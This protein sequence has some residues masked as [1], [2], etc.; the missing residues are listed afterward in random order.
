MRAL[1]ALA[2]ALTL[3]ACGGTVTDAADASSDGS[4]PDV[5]DDVGADAAGCVSACLGARLDWEWNGGLALY[6][7]KSAALPC[8]TYQRQRFGTPNDT[9]PTLACSSTIRHCGGDVV[10]GSNA[11]AIEEIASAVADAEVQTAFAHAPVLYGIDPRAYDGQVFRITMGTKMIEVG[12]AC[13]STAGC[14]AAPAGV[15]ALATLLQEL[16]T[17]KTGADAC[18]QFR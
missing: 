3:A 1:P 11:I 4:V 13:G 6:Y 8:N 17:R 12:G 5:A 9:T 10:D 2:L 14:K 7:D 16:D 15:Q 18:P